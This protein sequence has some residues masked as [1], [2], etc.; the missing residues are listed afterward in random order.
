[1]KKTMKPIV[2]EHDVTG[3]GRDIQNVAMYSTR[4]RFP[5]HC[6]ILDHDTDLTDVDVIAI[7]AIP[8]VT[9]TDSYAHQGL[10]DLIV[11]KGT[12]FN[13]DE[14]EPTIMDILT[15]RHERLSNPPVADVLVDALRTVEETI[16]ENVNAPLE[17]PSA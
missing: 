13:W 8:G 6:R 4:F 2:V 14:I 16:A 5:A 9:E 17:H 10:Y 1:M 15:V 7:R 12:A 3:S 11:K